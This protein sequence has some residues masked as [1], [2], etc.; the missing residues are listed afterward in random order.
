MYTAGARPWG[1]DA[2]FDIALPC[3]TQ[4]EVDEADA[5]VRGSKIRVVHL[6]LIDGADKVK[7]YT[8]HE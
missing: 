3:A 2:K 7:V 6:C 8:Q 5:T 4:N 1:A